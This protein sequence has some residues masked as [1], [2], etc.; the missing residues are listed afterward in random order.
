[1]IVLQSSSYQAWEPDRVHPKA[2]TLDQIVSRTGHQPETN[3]SAF[4]SPVSII[5]APFFLSSIAFNL[6][7]SRKL[8]HSF[9]FFSTQNITVIPKNNAKYKMPTDGYC[10]SLVLFCFSL[11]LYL[12]SG[13]LCFTTFHIRR[14]FYIRHYSPHLSIKCR[15]IIFSLQLN[16]L[17]R[18]QVFSLFFGDCFHIPID[19]QTAWRMNATFLLTSLHEVPARVR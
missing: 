18:S 15:I 8:A 1:M 7:T 12:L 3:F 14:K 9:S 19:I 2:M 10:V 13:K 17:L 5:I 6:H 4:S 11:E 16:L